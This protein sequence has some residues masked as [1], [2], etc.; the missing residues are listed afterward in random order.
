M[1]VIGRQ[2]INDR[3]N[4]AFAAGQHQARRLFSR[5]TKRQSAIAPRFVEIA[6]VILL[7]VLVAQIGLRLFTPLALPVGDITAATQQSAAPAQAIIAKNPF[8]E[9][10][11]ATILEDAAPTVADTSLDLLLTGV[12][13]AED[14]G[15]ATIE[16][17]DGKQSRFAVGD[18]IVDGVR[19]E[20]VYPDQV[21]INRSGVRESL[22]FESKTAL[23]SPPPP[24]AP[25]REAAPIPTTVNANSRGG[26]FTDFLRLAPATDED[27]NFAIDIYAARDRQT[28]NTY[29]FRDGDRVLSINGSP[30]PGNPAALAA[31]MSALQRDA[32]AVILVRR[33]DREIPIT[34]SLEGI[35]NQ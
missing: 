9:V 30:P 28:F 12:W 25:I 35:R 27:G 22:R 33:G 4:T 8:P 31:M 2:E 5:R 23:A 1:A 13:V 20:T 29:G 18:E 16:T 7:S 32:E 26:G 3:V 11:A 17:P 24:R 6:L 21:I 15:S 34:L 19:L 10:A 14:G